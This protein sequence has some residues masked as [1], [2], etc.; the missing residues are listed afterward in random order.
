ML[1]FTT[2]LLPRH[3]SNA[4]KPDASARA[5]ADASGF[6]MIFFLAGVIRT[7]MALVLLLPAALRADDWPQWRGPGRDGVW[8]ETGLLLKSYSEAPTMPD[9]RT[10]NVSAGVMSRLDRGLKVG[11]AWTQLPP[12][13]LVRS[14]KGSGTKPAGQPDASARVGR[15][16]FP[17]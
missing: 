17:R 3:E 4:W 1:R 8:R 16:S 6:R 10:A 7:A 9:K 14:A 11:Q 13:G 12:R 2:T 15:T 5:L